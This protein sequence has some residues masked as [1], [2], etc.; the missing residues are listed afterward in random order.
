MQKSVKKK[1]Y[2]NRT[3]FARRT[4]NIQVARNSVIVIPLNVRQAT[5]QCL[6]AY[7]K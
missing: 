7:L 4:F 6:V 5:Y 3:A 1:N 2:E